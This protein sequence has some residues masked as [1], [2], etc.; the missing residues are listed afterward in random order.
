[1]IW[2]NTLPGQLQFLSLAPTPTKVMLPLTQTSQ[3]LTKNQGLQ[4]T[5]SKLLEQPVVL[6]S[7]TWSTPRDLQIV[8]YSFNPA[9]LA[10]K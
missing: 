6:S 7:F 10:S 9:D 8:K 3:I 4:E 5:F 2:S 1:M